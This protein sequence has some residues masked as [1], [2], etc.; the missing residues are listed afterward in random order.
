MDR[1]SQAWAAYLE[2]NL[3]REDVEEC[4]A[5]P[6][7]R[8]HVVLFPD[9]ACIDLIENLQASAS[10]SQCTEVHQAGSQ[11]WTGR[12]GLSQTAGAAGNASCGAG[13][14]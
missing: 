14:V 6:Q 1:P 7:A 11:T 4:L 13:Q 2:G 12:Q 3:N 5:V 10:V 8:E 9:L